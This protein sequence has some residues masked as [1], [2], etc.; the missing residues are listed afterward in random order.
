MDE[1][2]IIFFDG[3]CNLCNTFIDFIIR[4][5]QKASF[6]VASLQG[7]T[8]QEE[9]PRA[10]YQNLSTVVLLDRN[11]RIYTHTDAVIRIV[12]QLRPFFKIFLIFLILP[13]FLRDPLYRVIAKY[14]YKLFGKRETC[15]LPTKE[16]R[17]Y[18]LP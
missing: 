3:H 9:L 16:E 18:F 4:Y 12:S 13:S 11:E 14:R 15:R 5:N 17:E 2:R 7:I 1:R 10:M 8:A 6:K